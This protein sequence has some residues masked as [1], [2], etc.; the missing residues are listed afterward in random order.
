MRKLGS[1][2]K[3]LHRLVYLNLGSACCTCSGW[4]GQTWRSGP[5]TLWL[6]RRSCCCGYPRSLA[7]CP[8]F[9]LVTV[10]RNKSFK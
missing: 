3:K 1:R 7:A 8:G 9:E 2:W 4:C 6:V 10:F 5:C